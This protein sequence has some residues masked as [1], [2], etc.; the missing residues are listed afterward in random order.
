[1][2][3]FISLLTLGLSNLFYRKSFSIIYIHK[4]LG[5]KKLNIFSLLVGVVHI[6]WQ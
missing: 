1:M 2:K 4:L 5:I 3:I 6:E